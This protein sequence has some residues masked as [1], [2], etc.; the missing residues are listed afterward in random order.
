[1]LY[2]IH[3]TYKKKKNDNGIIIF[4]IIRALY[5]KDII[6]QNS[7]NTAGYSVSFNIAIYLN[8]A[9]A[10]VLHLRM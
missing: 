1:M 9:K 3:I 4:D 6:R 7:N 8:N 10:R 5:E 2:V